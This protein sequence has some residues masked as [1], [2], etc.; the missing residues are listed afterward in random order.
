[1]RRFVWAQVM[2]GWTVLLGGCFRGGGA[3]ERYRAGLRVQFW[4]DADWA[5]VLDQVVTEDGYVRYDL[6]TGNANGVRYSLDRY[7]AQIYDAGPAN[8]PELFPSE[9]DRLAYYINA[10]NALSIY[11][12]LEREMPENVY[13]SGVLFD[14]RFVVGGRRVSLEQL[15]DELIRPFG[16]P[17]VH[18]ALNCMAASSPPLRREPYV[19]EWLDEQ[20]EEQGLRFL[21][22]ARAVQRVDEDTVRLTELITRF[23]PEDFLDAHQRRTGARAVSIIETVAP[24]A[25]ED[26]PLRGAESYVALPFDWSLNRA[27][28]SK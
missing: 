3:Y 10:Y 12:V 15:T 4:S 20:L 18:F 9:V 13:F 8:R 16:D 24:Y 28:G 7:V 27:K 14:P 2:L 23:Y 17:R 26:S 19:G 25:G 5:D 1:M 11:A 22:D 6:L 21:G